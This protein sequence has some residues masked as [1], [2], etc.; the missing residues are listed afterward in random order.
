MK[1]ILLLTFSLAGLQLFAQEKLVVDYDK[2]DDNVQ[3]KATEIWKEIPVVTPGEAGSPPSDAIVL[4]DGSSYAEWQATKLDEGFVTANGMKTLDMDVSDDVSWELDNG[5]MVV[6]KGAGYIR[7]KRV[8]GDVQLHLEWQSPVMDDA[9]GQG[10]SN[11]GVFLMGLY[12]VQVLNSYENKTYANGQAG[13]IYK[14]HMPLTNASRPPGTWQTYD[15]LFKAPIFGADGQLLRPAEITV[16]HNGV[17]VQ[18]GSVVQGPTRYVGSP[19]Y[20]PHPSKMPL[21]LQDHDNP[22][23]FRNIWVR[24]L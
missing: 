17:L 5:N 1:S 11:S 2:L 21:L 20:T 14:Q 15:I 22:V 19:R 9:S 24:E 8:F 12:E 3:A 4:F 23:R 7:T 10:Y 13:S 18:F 16:L 6:V